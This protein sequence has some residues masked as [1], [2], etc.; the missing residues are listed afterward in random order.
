MRY[1]G[2]NRFFQ[3]TSSL[4]LCAVVAIFSSIFATGLVIC[5]CH[6]GHISIEAQC[7]PIQCC[8]EDGENRPTSGTLAL[9]ESE[10]AH[11]CIDLAVGK[12]A[13]RPGNRTD[14]ALLGTQ[15]L[16]KLAHAG[17]GLLSQR[18]SVSKGVLA[19]PTVRP[20]DMTPIRTVVLTI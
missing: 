20:T 4:A 2:R 14:D 5:I 12:T 6:D 10:P 18:P 11:S 9:S 13:L 7:N 8:P 1:A 17:T 19:R 16:L 3:R 15:S